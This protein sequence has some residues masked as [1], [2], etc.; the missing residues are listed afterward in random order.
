M[1]EELIRIL[2]KTG[3]EAQLQGTIG[4]KYPDH[5]FTFWNFQTPEKFY[6]NKPVSAL[7]G[8]WVFFFS[9]DPEKVET[10]TNTIIDSL[11]AAGWVVEGRGEDALSD[12]PTHTGRRITVYRNEYY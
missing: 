6:D 12:E 8:F 3:Y 1:K 2:E 10:V 7:W 11:R 4:K 5:F 9:T